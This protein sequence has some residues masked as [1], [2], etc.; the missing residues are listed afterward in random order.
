MKLTPSQFAAI[1]AA[2]AILAK[3][4]LPEYTPRLYP[5]LEI[6]DASTSVCVD[7][8]RLVKVSPSPFQSQWEVAGGRSKWIRRVG[9]HVGS[10]EIANTRCHG[11]LLQ[12][13][14][15]EVQSFHPMDLFRWTGSQISFGQQRD[16]A[17]Q[18]QQAATAPVADFPT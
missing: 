6:D 7:L 14:T 13:A 16:L 9:R 5:R 12:F 8:P 4:G 17:V 1:K 3:A 2:N 15:G 10:I 18:A 11:I